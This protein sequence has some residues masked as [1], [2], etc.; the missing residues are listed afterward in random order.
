MALEYMKE[1]DTF[2]EDLAEGADFRGL[3]YILAAAVQLDTHNFSEMLRN[4]KWT[5]DDITAIEFLKGFADV[6]DDY[7]HRLNDA[8]YDVK[9]ALDMGLKGMFGRDY[10]TYDL[11]IGLMGVAVCTANHLTVFEHF[12]KE[13]FS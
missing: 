2:R 7:F 4:S 8:K 5:Q 1:V 9:A 3:A 10:K 11:G 6:G 12:G 13:A